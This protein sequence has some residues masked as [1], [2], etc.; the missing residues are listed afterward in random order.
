M[1]EVREGHARVC[2]KDG[3]P[4]SEGMGGGIVVAYFYPDVDEGLL[5]EWLGVRRDGAL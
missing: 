4:D 3:Y 5:W 2:H 1:D